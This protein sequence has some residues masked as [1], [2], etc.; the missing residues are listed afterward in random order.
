MAPT[1]SY[2]AGAGGM[3]SQ[4]HMSSPAFDLSSSG[5][6]CQSEGTQQVPAYFDRPPSLDEYSLSTGEAGTAQQ[7]SEGQM[8]LPYLQYPYE[9]TPDDFYN[10]S[11]SSV[12]Q[13]ASVL[14]TDSSAYSAMLPTCSQSLVDP[15]MWDFS[16]LMG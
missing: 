2:E 1:D 10:L 7:Q 11:S 9:S 13:T 14:G 5:S 8:C 16:D 4:Q 3:T 12:T 6:L 15:L